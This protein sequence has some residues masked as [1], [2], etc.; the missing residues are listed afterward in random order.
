M[1]A[2]VIQANYDDLAAFA[3]SFTNQAQSV[4]HLIEQVARLEQALEGGG[5]TGLGAEAFFAE[6]GD[7]VFPA[8]HRLAG[9]LNDARDVVGRISVV[10]HDAEEEA[11]RQFGG[12]G[13]GQAAG[14]AFA[15][16]SA[17]AF[18][19]SF[20]GGVF[21]GDTDGGGSNGA[22][23]KVNLTTY[24][25]GVDGW[26]VISTDGSQG[27]TPNKLVSQKGNTCAI[28]APL[29]LLIASGY[30]FPQGAADSFAKIMAMEG[31]WWRP[32]MWFDDDPNWGFGMGMSEDVLDKFDAKYQSGDFMEMKSTGGIFGHIEISPNRAKAE[33]FLIDNLRNGKPV[34]VSM[35]VDDSFGE[36]SGGH[37]ATVIGTQTGPD[38]RLKSVLIATNWASKPVVEVPA[39]AFMDD[40]MNRRGGAYI[41][42]D[43]KPVTPQPP[44][45]GAGFSKDL[46][47]ELNRQG[48]P[49]P[50]QPPPPSD[51]PRR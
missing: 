15:G 13:T 22:G 38:G 20:L 18:A 21:G 3:G 42:V 19:S 51:A 27:F 39:E 33:Q 46:L 32:D 16:A 23:K 26:S 28:Y 14:S 45:P 35:E 9:A 12:D 36:G 31:A 30:D 47:E 2:A 7:L 10:F 49:N 8:M 37:R 24:K 40:W 44:N 6:M 34:L 11:S 17:S 4:Q 1:P 5:W 43:R 50:T 29:N 25:N 41:T 48:F